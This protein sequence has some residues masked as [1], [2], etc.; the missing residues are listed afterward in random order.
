MTRL[1][2]LL[3]G[4]LLLACTGIAHAE[5]ASRRAVE[6]AMQA[7]HWDEALQMARLRLDSGEGQRADLQ[8][9][10]ASLQRLNRATELDDLIEKAVARYP[11]SASMESWPSQKMSASIRVVW[12]ATTLAGKRPPSISML[13]PSMATRL[14]ASS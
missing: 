11:K 8:A 5:E 3:I 13:T 4:G 6:D 9:A 10:A 2:G 14:S 7:G 12:P 1:L